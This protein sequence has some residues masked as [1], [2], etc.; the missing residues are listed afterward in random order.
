MLKSRFMRPAPGARWSFAIAAALLVIL[1]L[2]LFFASA[3]KSP[4]WDEP[5][6]IAS[7]VA[8]AQL[9]SLAVNPQ[10][11]PLLKALSGISLTIGGGRWQ[12]TAQ[13]RELL[14]GNQGDVWDV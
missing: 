2:Q 12:D 4:S 10:H 1:F 11:P 13:A 6:H 5:G 7:G 9:G 3:A 8:W 14:A